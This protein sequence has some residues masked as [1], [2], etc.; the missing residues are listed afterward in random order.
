MA[1]MLELALLSMQ[2]CDCILDLRTVIQIAVVRPC[3]LLSLGGRP[4]HV[5]GLV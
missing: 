4:S 3:L 5:Y 1:L 2:L